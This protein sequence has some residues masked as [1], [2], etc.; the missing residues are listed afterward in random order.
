VITGRHE[1]AYCRNGDEPKRAVKM[2]SRKGQKKKQEPSEIR[3]K[4]QEVGKFPVIREFRRL[5]TR[6]IQ[7]LR[8]MLLDRRKYK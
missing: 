7:L 1:K 5:R 4:G 2:K 6:G 8:K 3:R